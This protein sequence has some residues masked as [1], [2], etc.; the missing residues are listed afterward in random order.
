[1]SFVRPEAAS[2]LSRWSEVLAS[3]LI[4]GLGLWATTGSGWLLQSLGVG[5][6][7]I[8]LGLAFTAFRRMQFGKFTGGVGVV[9]LDERQLSYFSAFDGGAVSLD[10]LARVTIIT[11][12]N[13]SA[14]QWFFEEDGGGQLLIPANAAQADLLFDAMAALS[15]VDYDRASKAMTSRVDQQ[16]VIWS[17]ER[18]QLH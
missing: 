14:A 15:G 16:H 11:G 5:I 2:T 12:P 8:G 3:L 1:M 4:V 10:M 17:K 13:Q 6:L 7:L 9:D 18:A